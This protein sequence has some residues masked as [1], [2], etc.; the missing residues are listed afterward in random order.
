MNQYDP[1]TVP[2]LSDW[3]TTGFLFAATMMVLVGTFQAIAGLFAIFDEEFY[4]APSHYWFNL[5]VST[6]G[7]IHLILGIVVA[8]G[9]L[10]LF[11]GKAWAGILAIVVAMLSAISNFFYIPYYPFW[12]IVV[13]ALDVWIIWS[14]T[15][16]GVIR[17]Q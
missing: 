8:L 14:L 3:A 7:W 13:I 16:P 11:S 10:N 1:D 5:D 15:R 9:G 6:W 17:A 4:T 2:P 12:A